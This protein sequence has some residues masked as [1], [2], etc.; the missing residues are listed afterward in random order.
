M[1]GLV[2]VAREPGPRVVHAVGHTLYPSTRLPGWPDPENQTR[3]AFIGQG[4][5]PREIASILQE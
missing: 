2:N 5:E 4:L 3:L 1:K